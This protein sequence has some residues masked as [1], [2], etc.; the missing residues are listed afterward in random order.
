[1][2][3]TVTGRRDRVASYITSE[4]AGAAGGGPHPALPDD[5]YDVLHGT[6]GVDS[7][8]SD[9]AQDGT[10]SSATRVREEVALSFRR[11]DDIRAFTADVNAIMRYVR[12]DGDRRVGMTADRNLEF[13]RHR[14]AD[15]PP[16]ESY[17]ETP[18]VEFTFVGPVADVTTAGGSGHPH[19]ISET[20][21]EFA[22]ALTGYAK[23]KTPP[24]AFPERDT[25]ADSTPPDVPPLGIGDATG[26]D[27][28]EPVEVRHGIPA[29]P[30]CGD[31]DAFH[32]STGEWICQ[33]SGCPT[34]F[35]FDEDEQ[36]YTDR[37]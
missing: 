11:T 1:M 14:F 10:L 25:A 26:D 27:G 23:S 19:P 3:P 12:T 34:R 31:F 15:S 5:F 28:P 9:Y 6:Y 20:F 21:V 36:V 18:E 35:K 24:V 29:C 7:L 4:A 33:T 16:V 13:E 30:E 37:D 22:E 17:R 32:L 8:S 2:T